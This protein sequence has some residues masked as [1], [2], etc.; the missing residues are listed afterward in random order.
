[1]KT[2]HLSHRSRRNCEG[3][4]RR[5][6]L[7]VGSLSLLGLSLPQFLRL[8]SAAADTKN[9]LPERNCIL[10]FM[11]GGPSHIDT[12]DPKPEA[13]EEYRGEFGA[14]ETTASGVRISEH[15]PKMA[16]HAHRYAL[17]RAVT[18]PEGS[19]ERACHY[20]LTGYREL[21]TLQFPAYGSVV[22]RETGFRNSLPPYVAV[23]QTLRGGGTGYMSAVYQPFSAGNPGAAGFTVRDVKSP[24]G[25]ERLRARAELL[26]LQDAAFRAGDPDGTLAALDEFYERAYDLVSAPAAKKAFDLSQEPDAVKERYGKN[27]FG[28]GCLLARRLIEAGTRFVT[29]SQGGWDTHGQNFKLLRE[30][31]LPPLDAAFSSLLADLDDRGLLRET[32]VV[33][34]GEF[35][36]TPKVNRNAGRDHWPRCQSVVFAG[37]GVPGGQVVGESDATAS[38]PADRPVKPEDLAAT[39]YRLLG[40][41]THKSYMTATARPIRIAEGGQAVRELV[42]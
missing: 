30:R 16:Q 5:D 8:R 34:M 1:M 4:S 35:G 11:N 23:P 19:H 3:V 41:D 18:S 15:L 9:A 31:Q 21:P 42:G 14:I 6:L 2:I 25:E 29:V 13:P 32:L 20:M 24:V 28:M 38:Q 39:I 40:V 22:L 37:G 27:G 7:T 36:R 10:L 33:W 26:K 12:W 17:V